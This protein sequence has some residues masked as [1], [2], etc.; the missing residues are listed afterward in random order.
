MPIEFEAGV[1]YV[2][3][4]LC[5]LYLRF[6]KDVNRSLWGVTLAPSAHNRR[7]VCVIAAA[8]YFK[9]VA[10]DAVTPPK[11]AALS[12]VFEHLQC[13]Q[14]RGLKRKLAEMTRVGA[15]EGA[16]RSREEAVAALHIFGRQSTEPGLPC[17]GRGIRSIARR[18]P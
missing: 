10:E 1:T 14:V 2:V 17:N 13:D 6:K 4:D 3:Y 18:S 15:R 8:R 7:S 11:I 12:T 5:G 9:V 16:G